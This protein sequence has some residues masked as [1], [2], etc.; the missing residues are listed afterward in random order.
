VHENVNPDRS[1]LLFIVKKES[2]EISIRYIYDFLQGT[3]INKRSGIR[4]KSIICFGGIV[5]YDAIDHDEINTWKK[6][7]EWYISKAIHIPQMED[8][9]LKVKYHSLSQLLRVIQTSDNFKKVEHIFSL[10][11]IPLT[12]KVKPAE[13]LSLIPDSKYH[14]DENGHIRLPVREGEW[15]LEVL[16]KLLEGKK[17]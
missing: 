15:T 17:P 3:D 12:R 10:Y 13:V 4:E 2:Y 9:F 6:A 11:N 7:I 8:N 5:Y 16:I 1:T 14:I